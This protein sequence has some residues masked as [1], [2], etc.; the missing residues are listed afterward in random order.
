M[1]LKTT[2]IALSLLMSSNVVLAQSN[3]IRL[4]RIAKWE[5]LDHNKTIIYDSQGNTIAFVVFDTVYPHYLKKTGETFRFFSPTICQSDRV[6][7]SSSM[8]YI[9]T[10]ESIRK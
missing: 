5:V 1:K 9:S 10:I 4:D 3:C 7:I 6:Q 2:I 8:T